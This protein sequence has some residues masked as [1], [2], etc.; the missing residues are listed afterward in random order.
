MQ[1]PNGRLLGKPLTQPVFLAVEFEDNH[2]T[3]AD[4][5]DG[6]HVFDWQIAD[7]RCHGNAL[8]PASA[9]FR[10]PCDFVVGDFGRNARDQELIVVQ[11]TA[12][13]LFLQSLRSTGGPNDLI[14]VMRYSLTSMRLQQAGQ[15][16][17]V[18]F[19]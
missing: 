8:L 3:V 11:V 18:G 9:N 19:Q 16:S 15:I 1:L 2:G 13:T 14:A 12:K 6:F 4:L 5:N 10:R 7:D 17:P